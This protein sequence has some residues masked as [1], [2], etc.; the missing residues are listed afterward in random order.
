ML[1]Y[2]NIL[3]LAILQGIVQ[4]K[5]PFFSHSWEKEG[6]YVVCIVLALLL[7]YVYFYYKISGLIKSNKELKEKEQISAQI[8]RQ[9]EELSQK[10][11]SI[12]DSII[13]AKRIQ[14]AIMPS[15][16][17][18]KKILPDSFVLHIPKDIVSGDFYWINQHHDKI[19]VAAVDCT[20]H[21][22]PGAFMS[23]IGLELFRKITNNEGVEEP[24]QILNNLNKDFEQIFKDM[25]NIVLRDGMDIA[26][27]TIDNAN[28]S[29]EFAGAYNPLYIIRDEKIIEI[30]G[31]R[32]PIGLNI[33]DQEPHFETYKTEIREND[34]IY[35]FSDG[36]ADQFGGLEGKKFKYRRFRHLLLTIHSMPVETQL[37][38]LEKSINEWKGNLEQVD[39]ILVIGIRLHSNGINPL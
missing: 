10:N 20:G 13:Y 5:V 11:K 26:F 39:D 9:K 14:E 31:N 30:K 27:C 32:F 6:L 15:E 19:F 24:A 17:G 38:I 29:L 7:L 34:M 18:F 25:D 21:G 2:A 37:K 36:Y 16:K 35:I 8:K 4:Q 23:L 1:I 28:H 3:T 22:V 33:S 12:T